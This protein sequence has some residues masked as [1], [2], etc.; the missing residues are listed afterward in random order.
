MKFKQ[1]TEGAERF[2][3]AGIAEKCISGQGT[4]IYKH[5][6]RG[7]PSTFEEEQGGHFG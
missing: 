5:R 4:L 7:Q 3:H 1:R 6:G 2:N